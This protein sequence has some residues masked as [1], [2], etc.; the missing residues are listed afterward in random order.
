MCLR[1]TILSI[2]KNDLYGCWGERDIVI[3]FVQPE[4]QIDSD[5]LFYTDA[6][7]E[8][9]EYRGICDSIEWIDANGNDLVFP[10]FPKR[11]AYIYA[12]CILKQKRYRRFPD[13]EIECAYFSD[14]IFLKR[15]PEYLLQ[16][17]NAFTPN[18]DGLNDVWSPMVRDSYTYSIYDRWGEKIFE[19]DQ[20]IGW[21][22]R[23]NGELLPSGHYYYF[24]F[25]EGKNAT[26]GLIHLIR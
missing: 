25:Q 3:Q 11:D 4:I 7:I 9:P 22:G 19:G 23:K 12:N 2:R 20:E 8:S 26:K 15:K 16:L 10:Y 5:T 17:P 6:G 18:N 1:D 21:D 14:S 24:L 13:I